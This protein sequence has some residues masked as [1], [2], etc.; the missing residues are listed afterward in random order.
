VS[1]SV[2]DS[3]PLGRWRFTDLRGGGQR[4]RRDGDWMPRG[5]VAIEGVVLDPVASFMDEVSVAEGS[6]WVPVRSEP[7]GEVGCEAV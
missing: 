2:R 3:D 4:Q 6:C 1:K 7:N 5:S